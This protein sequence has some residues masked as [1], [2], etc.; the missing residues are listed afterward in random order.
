MHCICLCSLPH[1][2]C[3]DLCHPGTWKGIRQG[4][5][6]CCFDCIPFADGHVSQ[7]PGRDGHIFQ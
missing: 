5:L 4:E 3:T 1:S 7:E 2:V 6:I